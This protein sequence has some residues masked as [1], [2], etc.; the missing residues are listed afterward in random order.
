MKR[1]LK[2]MENLS[3]TKLSSNA[4]I[5]FVQLTHWTTR[6]AS[7]NRVPKSAKAATQYFDLLGSIRSKIKVPTIV[8]TTISSV[9][10]AK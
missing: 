9:D 10:I 8:K 1:P 5:G 6:G 7:E 3:T 2:I 4:Y